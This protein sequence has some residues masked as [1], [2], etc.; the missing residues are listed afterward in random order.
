MYGD[1]Y[2]IGCKSSVLSP[3]FNW[4][5]FHTVTLKTDHS[6][7]GSQKGNPPLVTFNEK[8]CR[9]PNRLLTMLM[10]SR[11]R[12][13]QPFHFFRPPLRTGFNTFS[14][15]WLPRVT[16]GPQYGTTGYGTT[17]CT[18]QLAHADDPV[19]E[20]WRRGSA[21]HMHTRLI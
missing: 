20:L 11:L 9:R 17:G 19:D 12:A 8:D 2:E 7:S 5:R 15:G 21:K 18:A 14:S 4:T 16:P 10:F 13:R 1:L 3:P 6:N